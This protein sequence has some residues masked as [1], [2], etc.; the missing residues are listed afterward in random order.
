MD[1]AVQDTPFVSTLDKAIKMKLY[2][3]ESSSET[4][5]YCCTSKCS[6]EEL[7]KA[8]ISEMGPRSKGP[9]GAVLAQ[10]QL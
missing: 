8:A 3:S 10:M 5:H 6:L 4:L 9:A 7:L 2:A 1:Y